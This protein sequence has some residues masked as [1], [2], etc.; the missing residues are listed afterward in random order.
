MRHRK[1]AIGLAVTTACTF[2]AVS[3]GTAAFSAPEPEPDVTTISFRWWGG[4]VRLERQL[5]A[6]RLFEELNPDIR[7]APKP[8]ALEN[9]LDL[10][11]IEAAAGTLP[12]IFTLRDT[13]PLEFGQAGLLLDLQELP[14]LDL[15][16]FPAK[17][18]ASASLSGHYFGVPAG[19]SALGVA[20]N[21]ELFELAGV[22]LPDDETWTWEE[23]SDIAQLISARTPAGIYGV[24]VRPQALLAAF[25]GQRDVRGLYDGNE[26]VVSTATMTDF[27]GLLGEL[28]ATGA[29][30]FAVLTTEQLHVGPAETLFS[31]DRAAMFF[32]SSHVFGPIPER[33]NGPV[34]ILRLPGD[35]QFNS[36][37][38]TVFPAQYI[39]VSAATAHPEAV[40][41]F[42]DFMVN[43][44]DAGRIMGVNRGQ[45]LNPKLAQVL[46]E[47]ATAGEMTAIDF[48]NRV[49]P[50]ARFAKPTPISEAEELPI[51]QR[52][53]ED[54]LFGRLTPA[55]AAELWISE[56]NTLLSTSR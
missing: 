40:A 43:S 32:V 29:A 49:S 6:I 17:A 44:A 47:V 24:E 48:V 5:E 50:T 20:V 45:P 27:F 56:I 16:G 34:A 38:T 10:L 33:V 28:V 23:F 36:I 46:P 31:L 15:Q 7:I 19:V 54:V 12:D 51:T 4:A 25:A 8:A 2:L 21:L 14:G 22:P 9:Y 37:G 53:L 3:F 41:R 18:L 35:S 26:L 42:L 11:T 55:A 13:W 52:R 30:P 39:A 1:S